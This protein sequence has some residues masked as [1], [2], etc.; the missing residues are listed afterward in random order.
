MQGICSKAV[1]N[2]PQNN[3][4]YQQYEFNDDFDINLYESFYRTHDPQIGRFWQ[5]DSKPNNSE[6]LFAAMAN[7]PILNF[8]LLGDTINPTQRDIFISNTDKKAK[9]TEHFREATKNEWNNRPMHALI[10]QAGWELANLLGL[11]AV[12]NAITTSKDPNSS[13]NDVAISIITAVVA[14][15]ATGEGE[16]TVKI[17]PTKLNGKI[18]EP[19]LPGKQIASNGEIEIVHYTRSG[20]HGPAHLHVKGGGPETKIGQNGKP[21]KG[22]PELT[23][24]QKAF[25]DERKQYIRKAVTQIMKWVN[26]SKK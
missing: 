7:N 22:S 21:I 4:K 16:G 20:D 19:N 14:T 2:A 6:S 15:A 24:A 1:T 13:S 9:R 12:D 18:T 10:M 23:T 8:D 5:L 11:T 26:Y 25:I 3:K 17:K